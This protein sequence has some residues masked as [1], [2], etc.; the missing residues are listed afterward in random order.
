ME[1]KIVTIK[2]QTTAIKIKK[3]KKKRDHIEDLIMK[4][5]TIKDHLIIKEKK[6]MMNFRMS[7]N[8]NINLKKMTMKKILR[9]R[10]KLNIINQARNHSVIGKILEIRIS[11]NLIQ[12]RDI[13]DGKRKMMRKK[14]TEIREIENSQETI[15][16]EDL[17]RKKMMMKKNLK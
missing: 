6:I 7:T 8:I 17:K 3:K 12:E 4:L 5:I 16:E 11:D 15:I 1:A 10:K 13:I 2:D 14:N 9:K